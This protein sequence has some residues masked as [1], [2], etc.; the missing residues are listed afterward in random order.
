[1]LRFRVE[2]FHFHVLPMRTRF[3]FRYG[4]A[5]LD[6]LP[7]VVVSADLEV[8]GVLHRGVSAEGLPPKWFTKDPETSFEADLAEMVAVIQNAS[9]IG[10]H[11]GQGGVNF[12]S[13]WRAVQDEQANWAGV[14]RVPALLAGLGVSLV[15]RAVLDGLCR[16]AGRPLHELMRAGVLVGDLGVVREALAGVRPADVLPGAPHAAVTVRHTVGLGDWL[17]DEEVTEA[18]G[19]EDGLPVSLEACVRAYGLTHFKIKLGG[20][21]ESDRERLGRVFEVVAANA[22]REW[23]CTL[24]GNE[25]FLSLEAFRVYF[26]GLAGDPK[27]AEGMGRVLFVEQPLRR[28]VCLA[29]EVAEVLAGWRG[30]PALL[31]DEGDGD[32]AAVPEALR[33]GY[34]GVSHKNCKGVLKGV[35]NLAMIQGAN[36]GDGGG[37][38]VSGEDLANVGPVALN[39]DLAVQ[40]MLGVGHVERNG[41]HYFR[42][43]SMWG[44]EVQEAVLAAHGDLYRRQEPGFP[45]LAIE[46]G[47]I[48]LASVNAAPFGCGAG[49]KWVEELEP[50]GAWI[51]RGGMS[52]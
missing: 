24:D 15:E 43:L 18:D 45:S 27:L 7:H 39:Q 28:D 21:L 26:E 4:I 50:L 46:A 49:V 51:R 2:G 52:D 6:W 31:L 9:R 34:R 36:R 1:M 41:H 19:P 17:R 3:P 42:G 48:G 35:A 40:A 5:S 20:G 37:R 44:L 29:E 23:R 13:W 8:N 22:G 10:C 12:G 25:A 38:F 14:R 16:A 33:L 32:L 30:A 47:R 11:A